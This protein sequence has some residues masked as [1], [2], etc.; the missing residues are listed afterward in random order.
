VHAFQHLL[1]LASKIDFFPSQNGALLAW[2]ASQICFKIITCPSDCGT[3]LVSN[4][5]FEM[6]AAIH[7]RGHKAGKKSGAIEKTHLV[8]RHATLEGRCNEYHF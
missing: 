1:I 3:N 5:D 8:S 2:H 7:S 6:K 4:L